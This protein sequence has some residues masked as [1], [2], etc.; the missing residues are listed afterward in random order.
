MKSGLNKIMRNIAATKAD[1][2][3]QKV[4]IFLFIFQITYLT[5]RDS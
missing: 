1:S 3:F 5:F 4:F 2:D